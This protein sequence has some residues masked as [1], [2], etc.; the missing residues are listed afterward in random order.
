MKKNS[1]F[2]R[3]LKNKAAALSLICAGLIVILSIIGPYMNPHGFNVPYPNL[4]HMPPRIPGVERL[5]IFDGSQTLRNRQAAGLGNEDTYPTGSILRIFNHRFEHGAEM[6]DLRVNAYI[7]R[8]AGDEYR[9]FGTDYLGRD[10]WTR[11]WRGTRLSLIIAFSAVIINTVIGVIFGALCGYYGGKVDLLLMRVTEVL[12]SLPQIA[13]FALLIMAIGT[14][15]LPIVFALCLRGWTGTA[16]I[17]RAQFL[18]YKTQEFVL[19]ARVIGASDARIIFRHIMPVAGG[20][21]ITRAAS[22]IPGA[23]FIE[24]FFAYLGLGIAAP[25]PSLGILMADARLTLTVAPTQ[26]LF[27][28]LV[29]SL[30][31]LSFNMLAFALREAGDV[32]DSFNK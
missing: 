14:G 23:I 8:G 6:V 3:F 28:A 1:Q 9:W 2:K 21:V 24:S 22:A 12:D 25:E 18:R 19:A 7:M 29:L 26:T 20:P 15:V 4:T 17:V 13:L 5:G 10:L 11:L 16:R 27:P 30:L 31:M 32:R